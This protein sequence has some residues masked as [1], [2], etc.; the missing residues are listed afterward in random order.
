MN[1]ILAVILIVV[2][3]IIGAVVAGGS[4]RYFFVQRQ[5]TLNKILDYQFECQPEI[6]TSL[7]SIQALKKIRSNETSNSNAV[8]YLEYQ[9]DCAVAGL[10]QYIGHHPLSDRDSFPATMVTLRLAKNYREQ[11]PHTN[12]DVSIQKDIEQAFSLVNHLPNH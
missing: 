2:A 10:G 11:F 4:V 8:E 9:L 1:K 3:F 5:V 12:Q 6:S 7:V